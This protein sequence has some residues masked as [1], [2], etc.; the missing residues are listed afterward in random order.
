MIHR[1]WTGDPVSEW[2]G[3]AIRSLHADVEVRDWTDDTLPRA[4][5]EWLDQHNDDVIA[6]D[7][8]RHRANLVRYWL[9]NEYGGWWVDHDVVLLERLNSLPYPMAAAHHTLCTCVLGLPAGHVMLTEALRRINEARPSQGR[10]MDVSGERFLD[11]LRTPDVTLLPLAYDSLGGHLGG[12][13][14]VHFYHSKSP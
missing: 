2:S 11:R 12:T 10:S 13:W 4:L 5:V 1:Y 3:K 14:A 9:L 7:R 8:L 6:G